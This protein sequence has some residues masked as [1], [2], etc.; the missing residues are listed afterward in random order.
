MLN[1]RSNWRK[2]NFDLWFVNSHK[3][4]FVSCAPTGAKLKGRELALEIASG[5]GSPVDRK[6][7]AG[8]GFF[9]KSLP[10]RQYC[11]VRR[12]NNL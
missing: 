9:D 4:S 1:F 7:Q 2:G 8:N 5:N 3:M 6:Q 10:L 11:A 12:S